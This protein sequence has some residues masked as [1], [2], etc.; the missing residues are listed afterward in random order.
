MSIVG[1]IYDGELPHEG[2]NNENVNDGSEN[3]A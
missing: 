2:E 1:L 3:Y